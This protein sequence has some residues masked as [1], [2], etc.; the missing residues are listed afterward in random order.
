MINHFALY[1][2]SSYLNSHFDFLFLQF[3]VVSFEL[4]F[5]PP[6]RPGKCIPKS[7]RY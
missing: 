1:F 5:L 7:E 3:S 6:P 2:I 4:S